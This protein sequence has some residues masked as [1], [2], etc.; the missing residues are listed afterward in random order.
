MHAK[1]VKIAISLPKDTMTEI[2]SIRHKLGIARSQAIF[3]AVSLWLKKKHEEALDKKY[4]EGYKRKP[5]EPAERN[6][7]ILAGLSSFSKDK[8]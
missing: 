2:E 1:A 4:I 8:W 5:E 6:P 7:L 3:E